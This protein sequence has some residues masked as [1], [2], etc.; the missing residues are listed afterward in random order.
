M[1]LCEVCLVGHRQK[2]SW[3]LV[4]SAA[5][6]MPADLAAAA[7]W[8]QSSCVGLNIVSGSPPVAHSSSL[9]VAMLK[10]MNMPKRRSTKA[11]C[12]AC[13]LPAAAAEAPE[14]AEASA[15]GQ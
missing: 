15:S 12:S 1:T 13:R 5:H 14:A 4:V 3:C 9:K 11:C 2:P 6:V 10:W 8:P 7:H